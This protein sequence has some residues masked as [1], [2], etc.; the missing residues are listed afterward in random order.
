MKH[1]TISTIG[2]NIIKTLNFTLQ[3][4]EHAKIGERIPEADKNKLY[5][6]YMTFFSFILEAP[7]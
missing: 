2:T 3:T 5:R 7:E 6:E 1:T 4:A